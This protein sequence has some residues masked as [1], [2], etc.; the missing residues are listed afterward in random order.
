MSQVDII[1]ELA[2]RR[3]F[4]WPSYALYGGYSGFYDFGP[5]GSAMKDRLIRK[6][7]SAYRKI[8]AI[9][10]DTPVLSPEA[11]FRASG[12]IEKFSDPAAE[13]EKCGSRYKIEELSVPREKISDLLTGATDYE[14]KCPNCGSRIHKFYDYNVMFRFESR[15]K[16]SQDLY[17][18]PETAQGMMTSFPLLINFNRGKLPLLVA[19]VGKGFRNEIAPRQALFRLRELTMLELEAYYSTDDDNSY[20]SLNDEKISILPSGKEVV[21]ISPREMF[22]KSILK[23]RALCFFIQV[24]HDLLM[25][26][27][28]PESNIRFRQHDPDERAHY[29]SDSWDAEVLVDNS[30]IEVE[31]IADRGTYDLTRHSSY[32]KQDLSVK[33]ENWSGIPRIVEPALGIDRLIMS[34]LC[35]A[36]YKRENGNNVLRLPSDVS[37]VSIAFLPLQKKDSL[38]SHAFELF[39]KYRERDP[40]A[41]Y[42]DSGSIGRRYARQDEIGTPICVTVDYETIST[43]TVTIRFRDSTKQT[44]VNEK[45][46]L[47]SDWLSSLKEV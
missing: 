1:T 29:A 43:E 46:L 3:G 16:K 25:S 11:V 26:S 21:S 27:G 8:G 15:D 12:H 2:K 39:S 30:W 14:V 19:Q 37:P 24:A 10:I 23:N 28:I 17:L 47:S 32:S 7:S 20:Y 5:L 42:D 4:F 34:I 18:R 9:F 31:G 44:R 45:D 40:F 13:C 41:T 36:Y 35:T 22:A 38:D 6:W 33:T